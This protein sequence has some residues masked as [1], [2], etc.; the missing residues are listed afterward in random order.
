MKLL[1]IPFFF[2]LLFM[3]VPSVIYAQSAAEKSWPSFWRQF[4]TAVNKKD[5]VALKRLMSSES[6]FFSGGGGESRD[7]W[8]QMLDQNKFWPLLQRSVRLGAKAYITPY[9][10]R[11]SRI[12]KDRHLIFKFINNRWR[13]VG[14]MG[15]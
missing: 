8:L 1:R 4:S 15:D 5:K 2:L 14:V 3:F 6:D 7:Q 12:T 9:E 11:L 10:K 13:F